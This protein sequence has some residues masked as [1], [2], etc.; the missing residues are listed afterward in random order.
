MNKIFTFIILLVSAASCNI[1]KTCPTYACE[2][3]KKSNCC[4]KQ[5][6]RTQ[7]VPEISIDPPPPVQ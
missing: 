4:Q 1:A 2:P 6:L 5:Q 3:S 7:I